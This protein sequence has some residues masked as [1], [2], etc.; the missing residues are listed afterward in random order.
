MFCLSESDT[1]YLY[2]YPTDMRKSFYS[3]S[4][5]VTNE[6]KRDVQ[7]GEAFIFVNRALT[8]MKILHAEYGGL[9]IYNLKLEKGCISLP[10]MQLDDDDSPPHRLTQWQ[11][12][13]LMT[14]GINPLEVKRSPRWLPQKSR[15]E[16]IG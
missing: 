4:G 8:S 1:F 9:V 5:I 3:L 13:V 16:K 15:K 12:L 11:E 10:D 14:Q 7:D 2:P 6:M